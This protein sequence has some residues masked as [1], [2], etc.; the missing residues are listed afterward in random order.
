MFFFAALHPPLECPGEVVIGQSP[1]DSQTLRL[2]YVR[3]MVRVARSLLILD[4]KKVCQGQVRRVQGWG[5]P[6]CLLGKKL[7]KFLRGGHWTIVLVNIFSQGTR[8]EFFC[9]ELS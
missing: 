4:K 5:E 3:A 6:R 1:D 2:N 9:R 7:L 8:S